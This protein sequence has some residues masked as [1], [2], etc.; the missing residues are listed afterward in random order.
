MEDIMSVVEAVKV[1]ALK[2]YVQEL[3]SIIAIPVRHDGEVCH[4]EMRVMKPMA[5]HSHKMMMLLSETFGEKLNDLSKMSEVN[6]ATAS[7][8]DRKEIL[9]FN[10]LHTCA[11][12]SS[13]CYKPE[14]DGEGKP[15][16]NPSLQWSCVED[17][18]KQCPNDLFTGLREHIQ[19][20]G[21]DVVVSEV[22]AKK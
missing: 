22:E 16:E 20:L 15:V 19:G 18:G 8:E 4:I 11:L 7:H 21:L 14:R 10:W 1:I 17:V 5:E 6:I 13:C 3:D 9:L 12:I 2:D